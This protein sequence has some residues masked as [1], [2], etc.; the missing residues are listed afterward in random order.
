M[1]DWRVQT[2]Q[3]E[4]EGEEEQ[5]KRILGREILG[6]LCVMEMIQVCL[7]P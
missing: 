5:P 6:P 2:E 3:E 4:R 7:S 1:R